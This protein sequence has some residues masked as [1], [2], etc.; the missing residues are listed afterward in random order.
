MCSEENPSRCHRHLLIGRVLR[1]RD[2]P[3][4]HIRGDGRIETETDL[5]ARESSSDLQPSLFEGGTG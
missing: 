3:V 2:V 4:S 1:E 5:A